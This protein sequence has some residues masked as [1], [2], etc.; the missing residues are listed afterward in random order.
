MVFGLLLVL[1]FAC[2]YV[3][4]CPAH[5]HLLD[6]LGSRWIHKANLA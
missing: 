6:D 1:K 5:V 3:K 2:F 4:V